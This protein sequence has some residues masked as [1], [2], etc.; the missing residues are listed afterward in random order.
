MSETKETKTLVIDTSIA[1]AAG[2]D[3]TGTDKIDPSTVCSRQLLEVILNNAYKI[4][5]SKELKEEWKSWYGYYSSYASKWYAEIVKRDRLTIV[6]N[7]ENDQLR[8]AILETTKQPSIK[9]AMKK[10]FFLLEMA[11][12]TDQIVLS[13]D[14][15]IRKYFKHAAVLIDEIKKILWANPDLSEEE[16]ILWIKK[17]APF[18]KKRQLGS[19]DKKIIVTI[20]RIVH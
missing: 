4:A 9:E 12:A 1:R 10:D 19:H 8:S 18:E 15:K 7:V 14:K 2:K 13:R 3:K 11:L 16:V 5:V 6:G 17:G 20:N